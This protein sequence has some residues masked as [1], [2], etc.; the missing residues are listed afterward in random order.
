MTPK[1]LAEQAQLKERL[2]WQTF[3]WVPNFC[4]LPPT[5]P[6]TLAT[7]CFHRAVCRGETLYFQTTK[8]LGT[9]IQTEL[10]YGILSFLRTK[11]L[12]V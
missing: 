9:Y 8:T 12:G 6:S 1:V 3:M 5:L 4:V 11:E 2:L 7:C 10:W